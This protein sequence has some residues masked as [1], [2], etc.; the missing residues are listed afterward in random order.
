MIR[1]DTHA[2]VFSTKD[3]VIETARYKPSYTARA[4][5]FIDNLNQHHLSHG[6][7]I[8]PS[9][10]GTD[11][12]AML[13]AIARYPQRLKGIAVIDENTD[14]PQLLSLQQQGITGIRLNLFGLSVPDLTTPTWKKLLTHLADI[15]FQVELHAPPYYL[16]QILPQL[17]AYP[18]D[19]V[20]DHLGRIPP[21]KEVSDADYQALLKQLNPDQHWLK[22]SGLYRLGDTSHYLEKAKVIFNHLK[23]EGFLEKLV[24]GSDWPHTQHEQRTNYLQ[25]ISDFEHVVTDSA[26]RE[27]ILGRNA[28]TLFGFI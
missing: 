9:F 11:N 22:I 5:D 20:L 15:H 14:K 2:H 17:S 25:C 7:L 16:T 8:Q 23:S 26:D 12:Q 3:K 4:E 1:I 28:A 10:L 24:W 27:L 21:D 18:L 6:V 13:D 19:V